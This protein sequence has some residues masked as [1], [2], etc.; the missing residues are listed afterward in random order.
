MTAAPSSP[1]P[2]SAL[3]Q[4]ET[5]DSGLLCKYPSKKCWTRRA[6]KRNGEMHNLCEFHRDKANKNQRRLELKRK[7]RA[8]S[9]SA[10]T[11][12]RRGADGAPSAHSEPPRAPR[13]RQRRR[14]G[15]P[16]GVLSTHLAMREEARCRQLA[17]LMELR[18]GA[19]VAA[20]PLTDGYR[21]GLLA[22]EHA[23]SLRISTSRAEQEMERVLS[24]QPAGQLSAVDELSMLCGSL[25]AA[26]TAKTSP[27]MTSRLSPVDVGDSWG[28]LDAA[29][30]WDLPS[31][32]VVDSSDAFSVALV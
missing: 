29:V 14:S 25:D 6:L 31:E 5:P 18:R 30:C 32:L 13:A 15:A 2:P 27:G 3:P 23:L 11:T 20:R 9:A 10:S 28:A 8:A 19:S 21:P 7:T 1:L 24:L 12:A 4:G 22:S 16:R 17:S 26:P